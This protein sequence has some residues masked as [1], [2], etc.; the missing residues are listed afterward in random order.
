M[1]RERLP[2]K[3]M[4]KI[5]GCV[6]LV[7]GAIFFVYFV[8]YQQSSTL[9]RGSLPVWHTAEQ[10]VKRP[11]YVNLDHGFCGPCPRDK[12]DTDAWQLL[13]LVQRMSPAEPF[14]VN[15]G[16]ASLSGGRYDPAYPLL[17]MNT[18]TFGALL[19]D[20]NP[21]PSLYSAYPVRPNVRI[22]HDYIW[23]ESV[24]PDIL[25]KYNV[26]KQFTV[27]KLDID[28]YECS[29]LESILAAGYRPQLI[30]TEFN[31]IFPPPVIFKPVYEPSAKL[32]WKPALWA[33]AGPFY[34]CSLSAISTLLAAF[35]YVLLEVDF[36]DVI[37]IERSLAQTLAVQVPANDRVAYAH[38]F[39]GHSCY[40]YCQGNAKLYNQNII[41]AI[42]QAS[43]Q[44]DFTARM[45]STLDAFAPISV[46][47]NVRHPYEIR[48]AES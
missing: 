13:D 5:V 40:S 23:A 18:S 33:N 32:D 10:R 3:P 45:T 38:G 24:V 17:A 34:G 4:P 31:P 6:C 35:D 1:S 7:G 22:T 27:F 12:L 37:Y 25:Q 9:T 39:V 36:W 28:S 42:R 43:N 30:H 8:L 2:T 16:A 44:S 21:N 20:P 19:I 29:V 47:S 14:L 26:T 48:L 15:I 11:T 46:K 41:T